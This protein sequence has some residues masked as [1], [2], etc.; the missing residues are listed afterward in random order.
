VKLPLVSVVIVHHKTPDLLERC[1]QALLRS[2][3]VYP[4]EMIVVDNGSAEGGF[5]ASAKN[6]SMQVLALRENKGFADAANRG[7][8]RAEGDYAL[9]LNAD[10]KMTRQEIDALVEFAEDHPATG[11]VGPIH[12][13]SDNRIQLT[14]GRFP[15]FS[16]EMERNAVHR[17]L[18][19]KSEPIQNR[20]QLMALSAGPVDWVSGS[21][22]LVRRKV[23]ERV[24][25]L[26]EGFFLYFEDIDWC[27]KI[28]D[29]GFEIRLAPDVNVVH[30]GGASAQLDPVAA[31]THY[32]N[33]LFKFVRRYHGRWA[34]AAVRTMVLAKSSTLAGWAGLKTLSRI[35]DVEKSRT[36][37]RVQAAAAKTALS[38]GRSQ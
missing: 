18:A 13:D 34:V 4:I 32:R 29:A 23:L 2:S 28:R 19:R 31:M 3:G 36:Q 38:I 8:R 24:G 37:R 15:T 1:V 10:V 22:M 20:L 11:I 6:E 21:C 5:G 16:S 12:R 26:D 9:L 27:R 14:W 35:G 7:L 30:V 33:S 17:E 25:F